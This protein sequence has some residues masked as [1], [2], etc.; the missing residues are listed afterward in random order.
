MS[1]GPDA[2]PFT[3]GIDSI[4]S[5]KWGESSFLPCVIRLDDFEI[6][7]S[8]FHFAAKSAHP[9]HI[10]SNVCLC[11]LLLMQLFAYKTVDQQ[12]PRKRFPSFLRPSEKVLNRQ[13]KIKG[14]T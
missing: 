1:A 7:L 8:V 5:F 3:H 13:L 4:W 10:H 12:D 6:R 2:L 9:H 11:I 14:R